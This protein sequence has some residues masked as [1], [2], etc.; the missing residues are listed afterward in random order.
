MNAN[1][2]FFMQMGGTVFDLEEAE[3]CYAPQY[4]SAKDPVNIAGEFK[5]VC[6]NGRAT[7]WR[8]RT[9]GLGCTALKSILEAGRASRRQG[10]RGSAAA[11]RGWGKPGLGMLRRCFYQH[12]LPKGCN[13]K[14]GGACLGCYLC[15]LSLPA[16][17]CCLAFHRAGM[18]ASNVMRGDT[19]CISW[20]SGLPS[21]GATSL[22]GHIIA[23]H[24]STSALVTAWPL[25]H[26]TAHCPPP[27]QPRSACPAAC[28]LLLLP[29]PFSSFPN[30]SLPAPLPRLPRYSVHAPLSSSRMM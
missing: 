27:R 18:V 21:A 15:L 12:L 8:Q 23:M 14:E 29:A 1:G 7:G 17:P 11:I 6:R 19:K 24:M 4:G 5:G 13:P 30:A 22:N 3:L 28:Y 16:M 10:V 26:L 20:V 25:P 2:V 9:L